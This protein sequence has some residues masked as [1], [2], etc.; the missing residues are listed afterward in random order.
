MYTWFTAA[1]FQQPK[2]ESTQVSINRWINKIC[3]V[4]QWNITQPWKAVS[5]WNVPLLR[6]SLGTLCWVKPASHKKANTVWFHLREVPRVTKFTE[7]ESWLVVAAGG[8]VGRNYCLMGIVSVWMVKTSW[9]VVMVT[10]QCQMYLMPLS[11]SLKTVKTGNFK[12][13]YIYVSAQ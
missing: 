11:C 9:M 8:A 4:T 12:I 2:V 6:W 7:T 10:Q 3:S 1:L 13:I 5:Y